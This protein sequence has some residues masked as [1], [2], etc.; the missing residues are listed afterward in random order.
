MREMKDSG[1]EWISDIPSVWEQRPLKALINCLDGKRIPISSDSRK[2]G[3][4]PYW[5]AGSITDYVDDYIFD[6]ELVLLG[7]DGAPFF[8][9]KRNVAFYVNEKVW[10]NNHIHVLKPN[11]NI[12]AKYLTH[13]LNIVDYG[14]YINGSILNK[15][16]QKNMNLINV[17]FPEFTEQKKI[18]TYLNLKLGYIDEIIEKTKQSIEEYKKYKQSL[19]TE[20]VTKGLDKNVKMK[21]SGIEWI[22]EIPEHWEKSKLKYKLSL[23]TGLSITKADF[24]EDGLHCLNY[25]DIH[26]R[27]NFDIDLKR[28]LLKFAPLEMVELKSNVFVNERDFVFCDTS[29]DLEGS[30]NCVFIK[31]LYDEILIAGSHTIIGR[32]NESVY[33]PYFAY[34]LKS[35]PIRAQIRSRVIGIKV[36]S[37]TQKILNNVE[38][39]MPSIDEQIEISIYL[40]VIRNRIDDSILKKYKLI[41]ELETYKKSLIYEVVTG[42]K[43]IN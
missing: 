43:E 4:Y 32:P 33:S 17:V 14:S 22:G 10:V 15:L 24:V 11:S 37:I 31:N 1:V 9:K 40:D 42:K 5:G 3:I 36:Y 28:D 35:D 41:E 26:S 19:I 29:E 16:T 2:D 27:Y 21:D 7:E 34:L 13:F 39:Y 8:D 12:D 23:S 6:E 18:A 20:V 30:G 38:F 25:G